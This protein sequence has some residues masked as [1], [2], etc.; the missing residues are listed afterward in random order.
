M[1]H[2][3]TQ[4]R[5]RCCQTPHLYLCRIK[6]PNSFCTRSVPIVVRSPPPLPPPLSSLPSSPSPPLTAMRRSPS[7]GYGFE[8][9]KNTD[10]LDDKLFYVYYGLLVVGCKVLVSQ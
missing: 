6:Q 1:V 9:N 10:W 7:Q 2:A 5:S 4:V 3:L 8:P